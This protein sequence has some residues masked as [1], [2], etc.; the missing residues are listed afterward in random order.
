[1]KWLTW[2]VALAVTLLL[3]LHTLPYLVRDQLVIWFYQQGI[4]RAA[5]K[6][7]EVDWLSGRLRVNELALHSNGQLPLELEQLAVDLDYR[8]LLEQRLQLQDLSVRGLSGGVRL[9]DEAVFVGP[10]QLPAAGNEEMDSEPA[11]SGNWQFGLDQ[12]ALSN[13]DWRTEWQQQQ[14]RL[15]LDQAGVQR[16]YQWRPGDIT[17]LNLTGALNG[18]PFSLRSDSRPLQADRASELELKLQRFPLQSVAALLGQPLSGELSSDLKVAL[19]WANEQGRL[20]SSGW[21]QLDGLDWRD[22]DAMHLQTG[23]L[24]WD[25]ELAMQFRQQL[26]AQLTVAGQLGLKEAQVALAEPQ[27]A[28][29]LAQS[30]W[31]GQA[32]VGFVDGGLDTLRVEQRLN[33]QGLKLQQAALQLVLKELSS[34]GVLNQQAGALQMQLTQI[35]AA[36][37]DSHIEQ[38]PLAAFDTLALRQLQWRDAG[39]LTID[40]L[41]ADQLKLARAKGAPLSQWQRVQL[42]K[43]ALSP[44]QLQLQTITLAGGRSLLRLGPNGEL[45][46]IEQLQQQLAKLTPAGSG[47]AQPAAGS[48]SAEPPPFIIKL[49][50]LTLASPHGLQLEDQS[51]E[52]PFEL[53][54]ELQTLEVGPYLS[55]PS[56]K[57]VP[58]KLQLR[59]AIAPFAKLALDGELDLNSRRDGRWQLQL[60]GLE[61]PPLSPYSIQYTGYYLQS[62]QFRLEADGELK[63]GQLSGQNKLGLFKLEVDPVAPDQVAQFSQRLSVPLETAIMVL[64]DNDQNIELEL[65]VSGSLDDPNFGYQSVINKLA[66]KGLKSAALSYLTKALQPYGTLISLAQT[67]IEASEKGAFIS[68][69][70]VQFAPGQLQPAG[71]M[72]GY[73]AKIG[74]MMNER[75][76]M[77]LTLCGRTVPADRPPLRELLQQENAKREQPLDEAAL[78]REL[79]RRMQQLAQQRSEVIKRALSKQVAAERLFLCYPKVETEAE[80]QPR[81]ELA[82]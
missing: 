57:N 18:A 53:T 38:Y 23:Q 14:Y 5:L 6:S 10:L 13:I 66:G 30:G 79:N 22:G 39:D 12:L 37:L 54:T 60:N 48:D 75:K 1:M 63:G 67:A 16:L 11:E 17:Q 42:D 78:A 41:S 33:L 24:R 71:D 52:P 8:A 82:L 7:I 51:H 72:D 69:Q 58:T 61:L 28:V 26:P 35:D 31:Q 44:Q 25:G 77:R 3:T 49:D 46:D 20:E 81:V 56:G 73:L 80:R 36:G 47:N 74:E 64:E 15:Q 29:N 43:L 62:G 27:L 50:K 4:E 68:L 55:Q 9:S 2:L 59:A 34:D 32:A 70:P 40:R 76:A 45:P 65:P 21:L 19:N